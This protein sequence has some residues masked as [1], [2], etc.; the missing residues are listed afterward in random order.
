LLLVLAAAL[1]ACDTAD[2]P[3]APAPEPA[4]LE[5]FFTQIGT[6]EQFSPPRADQSGATGDNS[7]EETQ[8]DG[9]MYECTSTP[10]SLTST[11]DKVVTFNPDVEIMWVGALLQGNGYTGGI[12]SLA[13][14]PIRQRTPLTLTI[15]LLTSDI[16]RTVAKP[17]SATTN[18][19]IG[20]LVQQAM[21]N[22]HSAG[23]NI[24]FTKE[25]MYS[26]NQ[27]AL[28]MGFSA[29]YSGATIKAS[30]DAST[31]SETRTMTAYFVQRMFTVHMV[32]PQHP[33]DLFSDAFTD[34][35]LQREVREGRMSSD[36]PPVFVSSISY[37]RIL[38]FSFTS[39]ANE[40]DINATLNAIY[41]G[42]QFGG[43]LDTK[44]QEILNTAQIE[45]VAV[46]GDANQAL[47]LIRSNDL[48]QYFAEDAP[49]STARPI[50]YTVRHLKDNQ[51]AR[52]AETTEYNL[53]TCTPKA[54]PI[55][56]SEFFITFTTIYG[57]AFPL[58]DPIAEG[59]FNA[60][61]YYTFSVEDVT[62]TKLGIEW[63]S[64]GEFDYVWKLES[65]QLRTLVD[66]AGQPAQPKKVVIHYDGR[67]SVR[68]FGTFW[69]ADW[70][71]PDDVVANFNWSYQWPDRK[72]RDGA[73][74]VLTR[75]DGWG[76]KVKVR[77]RITKGQDLTD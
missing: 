74:G 16:T 56:G 46:G 52:V 66:R 71:A 54:L 33:E 28:A 19:A 11:P 36:N 35:M 63:M 57:E 29:S 17:T 51:L 13:E 15:D 58:M 38:M 67:D 5:E 76:N 34:A 48:G 39:S 61:A 22:G 49:L 7:V 64:Q 32:L 2:D 42:G 70:L 1:A 45:V 23:S 26:Y 55:T 37:G 9:E 20:D 43:N 73:E 6:W 4:N 3:V 41:N 25:M 68:I 65:G 30:M 10:Y 62:G 27:F 31:S 60:E 12:G 40:S 72:M 24:D 50:S 8:I 77:W 14:L 47:A 53:T 44:Y 69:D 18:A 59:V 75:G 21:D